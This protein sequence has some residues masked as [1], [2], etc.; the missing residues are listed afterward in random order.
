MRFPEVTHGDRARA[1]IT[2]SVT[3]QTA[4]FAADGRVNLIGSRPLRMSCHVSAQARPA[5][6]R[7]SGASTPSAMRPS[8]GTQNHAT[9]QLSPCTDHTLQFLVASR[10]LRGNEGIVIAVP[11]ELPVTLRANPYTFLINPRL[12]VQSAARAAVISSRGTQFANT[13]GL[14]FTGRLAPAPISAANSSS[15]S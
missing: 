1:S 10:K 8:D 9:H 3:C 11:H 2:R 15:T 7:R 12:T 14:G 5:K 6:C 13:S 4:S